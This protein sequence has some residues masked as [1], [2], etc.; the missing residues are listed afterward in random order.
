[1][2]L[3]NVRNAAE[4]LKPKL[5]TDGVPS[6]I[7][8]RLSL[9]C[10]KSL[11]LYDATDSLL[12]LDFFPPRSRGI[13]D[14]LTTLTCPTGMNQAFCILPFRGKSTTLLH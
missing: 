3:Q 14:G 13:G 7:S 9:S 11:H 1:M 10:H 6:Q 2:C 12:V 5:H 8:A 4:R